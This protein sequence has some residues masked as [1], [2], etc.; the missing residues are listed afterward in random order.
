M[1][2]PTE[3][4][5]KYIDDTASK[6]IERLNEKFQ[7]QIAKECLDEQLYKLLVLQNLREIKRRIEDIVFV[8]FFN[9]Y[10]TDGA[11]EE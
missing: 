11:D 6:L 9:V 10:R 7:V 2:I 4:K 5:K 8:E 3:E 1:D